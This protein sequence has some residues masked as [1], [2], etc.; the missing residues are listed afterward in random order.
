VTGPSHEA[1]QHRRDAQPASALGGFRPLSIP[2]DEFE[3]VRPDSAKKLLVA[4][5]ITLPTVPK[6]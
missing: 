1:R 4:R 3:C 2:P 6:L 5:Q